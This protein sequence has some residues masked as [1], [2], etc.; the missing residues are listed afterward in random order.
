MPYVY[1]MVDMGCCMT[2]EVYILPASCGKYRKAMSP[3]KINLGTLNVAWKLQSSSERTLLPFWWCMLWL[4][5]FQVSNFEIRSRTNF[6]Q[7][8]R[9][10]CEWW[11]TRP[12]FQSCWKKMENVY[13]KN[14]V[15][16]RQ[17]CL[18]M[19]TLLGLGY[20]SYSPL[21]AE[22]CQNCFGSILTNERPPI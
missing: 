4:I 10:F 20:F 2:I 1:A 7:L 13:E 11:A 17:N 22:Y 9:F 21:N 8:N 18:K 3:K 6:P 15:A 5:Q 16:N 12:L 19:G 14:C